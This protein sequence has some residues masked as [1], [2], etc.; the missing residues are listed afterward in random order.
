MNLTT[1]DFFKQDSVQSKF[2][3]LLGNRA[4]QFITSVLQIANNNAMLSNAD[5]VSI[6]NAAATAAVLDLPINP[7]LGFAYII[8]FNEKQKDG[9][10]ISKA[11]FQIGYKGF[12]QL[13]QRSGQFKTLNCVAVYE[14]DEDGDVYQ[15]LINIIPKKPSTNNIVGYAAFF[16]LLNGFEKVYYMDKSQIESHALKFS[17]TYKKNFG[18]WKDDFDSM[19]KKTVIKLLLNKYAPLSIEMQ[20]AVITDQAIINDVNGEDVTYL[21]NIANRPEKQNPKEIE[22]ERLCQLIKSSKSID[23]LKKVT[24]DAIFGEKANQLFDEKLKEL[25]V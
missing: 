4:N 14:G 18:V 7:N 5:P 22:Q 19:A 25:D 9:S 23:D 10:Y 15:R 3:E 6:Y 20:K 13:A 12:I 16:Q 17:Q 21:D 8:P 11:Q 24:K 2:K 1:K